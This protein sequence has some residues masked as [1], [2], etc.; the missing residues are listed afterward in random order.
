LIN[1]ARIGDVPGLPDEV[2]HDEHADRGLEVGLARADASVA[3]DLKEADAR[4]SVRLAAVDSAEAVH[5]DGIGPM[6]LEELPQ[7]EVNGRGLL[8]LLPRTL[9]GP[10]GPPHPTVGPLPRLRSVGLLPDLVVLG[11]R[12]GDD[13]RAE[14][15]LDGLAARAGV[16]SD[17]E[18]RAGAKALQALERSEGIAGVLEPRRGDHRRR[19]APPLCHG[20]RDEDLARCPVVR[21]D[22]GLPGL[23]NE[24]SPRALSLAGGTRFPL[25]LQSLGD[26]TKPGRES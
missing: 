24:S 3:V 5:G 2:L 21:E 10:G 23:G 7:G 26:W 14:G 13:L 16:G 22:D 19:Q 1:T 12:D 4:V 18:D 15:V 20:V 11:K 8:D 17:V 9:H 6:A 25:E